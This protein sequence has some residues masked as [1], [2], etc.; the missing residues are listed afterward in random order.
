MS[1]VRD[2]S[3]LLDDVLEAVR[4]LLELGARH[5]PELGADKDRDEAILFNLIV[6]GEATKRLA[7]D[8]RAR[9]PDIPWADMAETRDRV[10]HHYEG[11]DWQVIRAILDR[12]L[13]P[14][15]PRLAAA[16]DLLRSEF[17][18]RGA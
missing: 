5:G 4:R 18:G 11:V 3:L 13:P 2:E 10:V 1:G 15:I 7:V 8:T 9:F 17:D 12:D 16:R 14:L 6:M